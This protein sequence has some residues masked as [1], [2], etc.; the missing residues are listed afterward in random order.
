M[1]GVLFTKIIYLSRLLKDDICHFAT[2]LLVCITKNQILAKLDKNSHVINYPPLKLFQLLRLLKHDICHFPT[3]FIS[4]HDYKR[5]FEI[6]KLLL[7]YWKNIFI[8]LRWRK[9][10]TLLLSYKM[11]W[12]WSS[13]FPFFF[14]H[15]ILFSIQYYFFFQIHIY[16]LTFIS[17][18]I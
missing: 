17:S 10:I 15:T 11:G 13:F 8:L 12:G 2:F 5:S 3:F 16:N 4:M 14:L 6:E 7:S 18:G 9:N 1:E